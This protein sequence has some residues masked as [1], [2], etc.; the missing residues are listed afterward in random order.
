MPDIAPLVKDAQVASL[1][2]SF[3]SRSRPHAGLPLAGTLVARGYG[4]RDWFLR[5][6]LAV[7]DGVCLGVA[8]AVAMV[9]VGGRH[10]HSWQQ[11]LLYGLITLPAWVVLFKMYGLYER[12][13]KRLSHSTLDDLPSLF[14][15][16]LLGCLL[17]WCWFVLVAPAKLMFTAILVF[18][19]WRWCSC[20]RVVCSRAP[21]FRAWSRLSGC[22]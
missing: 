5:R 15:G 7:S 17:M 13:A 19:G 16:V 14:H 12:D 20:W 18:G 22:C 3:Q 21:A 2:A 11:Y 6:L 1:D 10:G 8:M 4:R 9:V